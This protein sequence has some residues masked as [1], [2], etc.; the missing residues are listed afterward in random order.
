MTKFLAGD[1]QVDGIRAEPAAGRGHH[2]RGDAGVRERLPDL[3]AW[4]AVSGRPRPARRRAVGG[5]EQFVQASG[6]LLLL[7][8]A[9]LIGQLHRG[10][11][12]SRSAITERWISLVPA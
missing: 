4:F 2:E 7:V 12:S 10:S 11:P 6:E 5:R 3:Q 9:N 1:D 8:G